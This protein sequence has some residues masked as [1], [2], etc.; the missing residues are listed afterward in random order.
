[1]QPTLPSQI[2]P[3]ETK[4]HWPSW[5]PYAHASP[6][7]LLLTALSESHA[8]QFSFSLHP[9][10]PDFIPSH[11]M[12]QPPA[13][14]LSTQR[15]A[16]PNALLLQ[17]AQAPQAPPVFGILKPFLA[18]SIP[19][20]DSWRCCV[21]SSHPTS[22]APQLPP[23]WRA[24]TPHCYLN[25]KP[26][27]FAFAL[28]CPLPQCVCHHPVSPSRCWCCAH[29]S[30]GCVTPNLYSTREHRISGK[31]GALPCRQVVSCRASARCTLGVRTGRSCGA[32]LLASCA[33]ACSTTASK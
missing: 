1:M 10:A 20:E 24:C 18:C 11:R 25:P 31:A 13:A 9:P 30:S 15:S 5:L 12:P 2:C 4:K 7:I 14:T 32:V 16:H 6:R 8:I 3:R 27:S 26:P 29:Y 22:T 23:R 19:D 33:R 21:V 28:C 17:S